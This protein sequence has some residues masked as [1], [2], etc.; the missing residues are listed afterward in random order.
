M[1][2]LSRQIVFPV[3][4][5]LIPVLF[6]ILM[7]AG[8][9]LVGFGGDY[10]LFQTLESHPEYL[11]PNGDLARRYFSKQTS[12]PS[13][14][15]D[16]F[17]S[18]K[19]DDAIRVFV[20]GGSTAAG[21]PYY[22]GVSLA[23]LLER[24]L[25]AT[26]PD[27][28]VEVVGTA[29][30][31]VN[32][33][34]LLDISDEII[35]QKP[36]AVV[37][38]AGHNEYYGALGAASTESIGGAT[39]AVR[40]YLRLRR[41]RTVQA[42]RGMIVSITR[43][44]GGREKEGPPGGTLMARM[45][46]Q[47]SIPFGSKNFDRGARQ[48]D[49]NL[50]LL[51]ER[52]HEAGVKVFV[53]TLTSNVGD[54]EPFISGSANADNA[55]DRFQNARRLERNGDTLQARSEYR[56]AK[57]MDELRFRAPEVFNTTI[58]QAAERHG[59]VIVDVQAVMDESSPRGIVGDE[60]MT[61]HLH[62]NS[63]GYVVM[64]DAFYEALREVGMFGTWPSEQQTNATIETVVFSEIDSLLGD[65]R[66]KV[67]R[68][69]WPFRPAGSTGLPEFGTT[70]EVQKIAFD[71]YKG[72]LKRAEGLER[73]RLLEA[74]RGNFDKAIDVTASLLLQ[75]P[76]ISDPHMAMAD[77]LVSSGRSA[78]ALGHYQTANAL[79]E[80]NAAHRMIGSILLQL[81][82]R[83]ESIAHLER[84]VEMGPTDTQA[85]YNLSGAY[86][87]EMRFDDARRT[88]VLLL[89]IDAAHA[90]GRR[91]LESLP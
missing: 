83:V 40:L 89:E 59:A 9:R 88:A 6:F 16:A 8:L 21:F 27:R 70:T 36:D 30:A 33:F 68:N 52:Y 7:E 60:F 38:Y 39:S 69:S 17:R 11:Y 14:P 13:I 74:A 67:L 71:V 34:T 44:F 85:L 80:S 28:S 87:L 2:L 29:M 54:H 49:S 82:R 57:D 86:A 90:G 51:L 5:A 32:S 84:A 55:T 19:G 25:A 18:E 47:Q 64:A 76:F 22:F 91:L 58:R 37:L 1:V 43:Q 3:V 75:Y 63:A 50:N 61:E 45:V 26:F 42:L 66:I 4:A 20:Q 48:F 15:F 10:P 73:L 56:S 79:S 72:Q 12:L 65:Y 31:A 41:F 23:D 53:G 78:D 81:G 62:P 24:R 35:E 77:L 46:G